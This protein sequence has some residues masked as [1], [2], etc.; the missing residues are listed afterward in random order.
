MRR[1]S[2]KAA[3]CA[4]VLLSAGMNVQAADTADLVLDKEITVTATRTE[5]LVKD[6]PV[7]TTIVTREEI[8]A[9]E[10]RNLEQALQTISGLSLTTDQHGGVNVTMRGAETR[11]TLLLIDGR[12]TTADLTKTRSNAMTWLRQSMDNIERIEITRG[13]SSALYG[14]EANGGVINII[15]KRKA[16]PGIDVNAEVSVRD[17]ANG[18]GYNFAV[19]AFSGQQGK[20]SGSVGAGTRKTLAGVK[21]DGSDANYQGT[22]TPLHFDVAYRAGEHDTVSFFADRTTEDLSMRGLS[23]SLPYTARKDTSSV[24]TGIQYDGRRGSTDIMLRTY[25]NRYKEAYDAYNAAS[26]LT[27]WDEFAHKEW[28]TELQMS[29]RI[30]NEHLLTYGAEY[31]DETGESTRIVTGNTAWTKTRG[32][33]AQSAGKKTI[34]SY[35]AYVQDT[36]TPHEKWVVIP[37]LRFDGSDTFDDSLSPKIGVTYKANDS[38]RVKFNYGRGYSAPGMTELYHNWLMAT[39]TMGRLG[40]VPLY[41]VGNENL[42]EETSFNFDLSFEKDWKKTQTKLTFFH[43]EIKNYI[44]SSPIMVYS[45]IPNTSYININYVNLNKAVLRGVELSAKHRIDERWDIFVNYTYLDGENRDSYTRLTNQPKHM[46]SAGAEYRH[47]KWSVALWGNY[48]IDYLEQIGSAS[49][50]GA[51]APE[52]KNFGIWNVAVSRELND[53]TKLYV[54]IDNIFGEKEEMR[55]LNGATYRVGV[56][57]KL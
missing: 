5:A 42:I 9:R 16:E 47:G 46:V 33:I 3:I 14:S 18:T 38:T 11:H 21:S 29:T 52:E 50:T 40:S 31:R 17:A 4:A 35:S 27:S 22:H 20:W 6:V 13:P 55:D 25:Y 48:Y 41:L 51:V 36:W 28:I 7:T 19:N 2:M 32:G 44:S 54:G 10:Y 37:A 49:L 30:G 15:T 12:R 34:G 26:T 53:K 43:N 8:E 39:V 23:S 57:L 24:S 45:P 56:N 1:Y